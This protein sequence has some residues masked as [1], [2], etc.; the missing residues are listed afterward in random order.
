MSAPALQQATVQPRAKVSRLPLPD[1]Y[2]RRV[3]E[4]VAETYSVRVSH[5]LG[6]SGTKHVR[7]ARQAAYWCLHR[8]GR[9][10]P[11]VGRAL[12]RNHSTVLSGVRR[13]QHRM[14]HDPYTCARLE[15]V[16]DAVGIPRV[17]RP[18]CETFVGFV[19]GSRGGD[20]HPAYRRQTDICHQPGCGLRRAEH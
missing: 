10:L 8:A 19:R 6:R 11:A 20:F 9:S 3:L 5:L 13:T 15:G 17:E 1:E 7:I 12:G 2:A 16:L 4:L 18:R 14:L